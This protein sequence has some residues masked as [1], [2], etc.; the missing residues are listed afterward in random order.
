MALT[1][2]LLP[3][4]GRYYWQ[5]APTAAYQ[6][7]RRRPTPPALALLKPCKQIVQL[8]TLCCAEAGALYTSR[9]AEKLRGE[10]LA[11]NTLILFLTT[12]RFGPEPQHCVSAVLTLAVATDVTPE[13]IRHAQRGVEEIYAG[14]H[15]W[16]KAGVMLVG[17]VSATPVQ[18]GLFDRMDHGRARRLMHV[19]DRINARMGRDTIRYAATGFKQEWRTRFEKCSPRYTTCRDELLTLAP[20]RFA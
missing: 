3:S 20:R 18:A 1:L 7:A 9:A 5:L 13:L 8:R 17:L 2:N 19:I 16:K 4:Q 15:R 10:R 11:A 6:L 14:G 12:S